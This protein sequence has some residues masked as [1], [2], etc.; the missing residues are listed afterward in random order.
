MRF[1]ITCAVMWT[2]VL[3][4]TPISVYSM[5]PACTD[6]SFDPDGDG[7]GWEDGQTCRVVDDG[8]NPTAGECIDDDGDG[9]GWDGVMS[10]QIG[11]PVAGDCID[12]DG[13][14]WGWDG[15]AS[16]RVGDPVAGDCIDDDEDGWGWDGTAS[17]IA[18]SGYF[19]FFPEYFYWCYAKDG[20]LGSL[21][22]DVSDDYPKTGVVWLF[23]DDR[24][25][26]T[27]DDTY[28]TFNV[29]SGTRFRVV[30]SDGSESWI[31]ESR[32]NELGLYAGD[33]TE[34]GRCVY[35]WIAF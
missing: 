13:D 27:L 24:S 1:K 35:E 32:E 4:T 16:C 34:A 28:G 9:W 29:I 33:G 15:T 11:D 18:P 17:C 21:N 7:W 20:S 12:D 6:S 10:C 26:L 8:G 22:D 23:Y 14:G 5:P 2:I 3:F 19:G 25:V 30:K 31:V